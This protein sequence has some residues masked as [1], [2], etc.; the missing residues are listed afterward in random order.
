MTNGCC[1]RPSETMRIHRAGAWLLSANQK[2]F[3]TLGT[4]V[5]IILI[6]YQ[7]L[8]VLFEMVI[9]AGGER[10]YKRF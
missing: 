2:L 5:I 1:C 7:I 8:I 3:S 9:W 6:P 4:W 10:V